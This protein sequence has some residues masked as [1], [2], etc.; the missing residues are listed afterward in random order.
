MNTPPK[1]FISAADF[2]NPPE[3]IE[4]DET[5]KILA[6]RGK[7]LK[8]VI[9]LYRFFWPY[10]IARNAGLPLPRSHWA[11]FY[12]SK[13]GERMETLLGKKD[14]ETYF[15]KHDFWN[16]NVMVRDLW[17]SMFNGAYDDI[18]S[19]PVTE[20][21][22]GFVPEE[23]SEKAKEKVRELHRTVLSAVA[24]EKLTRAMVMADP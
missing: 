7:D 13:V 21:V 1:G 3:V 20:L 16:A 4:K 22:E 17:L 18:R 12:P 6:M 9:E 11:G 8:F 10:M 24:E 5:P 15:S 19:F 23:F 14:F 2:E